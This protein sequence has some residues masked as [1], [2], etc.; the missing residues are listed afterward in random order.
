M[1]VNDARLTLQMEKLSESQCFNNVPLLYLKK[2]ESHLETES[3]DAPRINL[4]FVSIV[5]L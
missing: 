2:I 3:S 4:T 1:Q 5:L